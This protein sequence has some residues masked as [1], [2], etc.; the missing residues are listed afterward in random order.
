[1]AFLTAINAGGVIAMPQNQIFAIPP[2]RYLFQTDATTP[3]VKWST[4]PAFGT[5]ITLTL[6]NGEC[7]V[8]GGYI[9][10]TSANINA[11]FSHI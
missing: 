10:C 2:R 1:M 11:V 7:E 6:T 8:A 3:T 5:S 9:Q 4:D